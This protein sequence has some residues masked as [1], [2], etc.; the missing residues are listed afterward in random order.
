MME[1]SAMCD[2]HSSTKEGGTEKELGQIGKRRFVTDET[3]GRGNHTISK[4]KGKRKV[5]RSLFQSL[6]Y[7][8]DLVQSCNRHLETVEEKLAEKRGKAAGVSHD[9]ESN[10]SRGRDKGGSAIKISDHEV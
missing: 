9:N 2:K 5:F 10:Q 1:N 8:E 3:D 7:G 4:R 6:Q